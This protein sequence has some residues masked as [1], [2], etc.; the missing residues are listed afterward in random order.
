M[1]SFRFSFLS[2]ST[3]IWFISLTFHSS[4]WSHLFSTNEHWSLFFIIINNSWTSLIS[5]SHFHLT[6]CIASHAYLIFTIENISFSR[7]S[8]HHR[9]ASSIIIF[10][11]NSMNS[12]ENFKSQMTFVSLNV[13]E[14]ITLKDEIIKKYEISLE[15]KKSAESKTTM[16][17]FSN[18]SCDI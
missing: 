13:E 4:F 10:I 16:T 5:L 1:I 12:S 9:R 8:H 14:L 2:Q 18:I 3:F 7:V 17:L 6:L 15:E 11:S